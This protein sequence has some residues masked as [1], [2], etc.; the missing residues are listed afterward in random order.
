MGKLAFI[1]PGQGA[2][3]I[4]M[5]KAS[6]E[7]G[8]ES[9]LVFEKANEIL[10][11]DLTKLCF[12]GPEEELKKTENSQPAILTASV[13]ALKRLAKER[14]EVKCDFCL[15]LS[16]GE[17]T[18]LIAAGSMSFED[19]VN[20]VRQRG[21]AMEE[22]AKKNT[23]KMVSVLGLEREEVIKLAKGC[24]CEVA[25]LNCP[26]QVVISGDES[27]IEAACGL[28]KF[29][30]AKRVIT[31]DVSG[32]FH[33]NAMDPASEKLKTILDET[34]INPARVPVI[35]NVTAKPEEAPDEI[36]QNL[37]NQVNHTTR[38]EDSIRYLIDQ[39]VKDYIEIGPGTVLKGLLRRI[40][41]RLKVE[42][43]E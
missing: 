20:L 5:G 42:N 17:Y 1:F 19:G 18:A 37:V 14:P 3:Y 23:G 12:E 31:L 26:G 21:E 8:E 2:Q 11:F 16:L 22:A 35:A 28:A 25:N 34:E 38:W 40:E 43:F 24:G 33:S 32:P 41:P 15:G 30:G 7:A 36:R 4:G 27:A 13:A 39:E 9:R 10:G 6:F 29:K